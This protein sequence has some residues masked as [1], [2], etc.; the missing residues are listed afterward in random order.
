[1]LRNSGHKKTIIYIFYLY[2]FGFL[3]VFGGDG[4]EQAYLFQGN[5]GARALLDQPQYNVKI[6]YGFPK[7]MI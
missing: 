7:I 2:I 4:G 5:K 6:I 3:C 1:M